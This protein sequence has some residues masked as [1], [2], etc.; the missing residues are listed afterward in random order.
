M[1]TNTEITV[2]WPVAGE[3]IFTES[4]IAY[5]IGQRINEGGYALVFEGVDQFENPIALKI[6]KPANRP[7][8]EVQ[9][10]WEQETQLF[11]KLRHSNIVAIYDAFIYNNL[12]YIVL[13]KAWGNLYEWIRVSNP[14]NINEKTV[15]EIAR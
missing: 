5:T 7:F 15:R 9:K 8:E 1:N 10:Q 14:A 11:Y 2:S 6:F 4:G 3:K 13:E 12:F